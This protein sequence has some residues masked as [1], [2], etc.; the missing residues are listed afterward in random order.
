L[1]GAIWQVN[2]KL[3]FDAAVRYAFVN[4]RPVQELRAGL[5]F[6]FPLFSQPSS[7]QFANLARR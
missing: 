5:T 1:A 4:G 7:A 3:S 2:D 6:G